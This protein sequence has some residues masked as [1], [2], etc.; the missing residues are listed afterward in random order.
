MKKLALALVCLIIVAF[1]A[2]CTPQGQPS[3]S[4]L[5]EEG[6][7]QNED[8]VNLG[9]EVNFGFTMHSAIETN[10]PLAKL[11]IKVDDNAPDTVVLTG[12]SFTYR[13]TLVYGLEKDEI[14]GS[15]TITATVYDAAGQ[16]ASTSITLNLNQPAQPLVCNRIEWVRRGANVISEEEMANYGLQWT[17]SYNS[18]FA[19]LKP[20]DGATLYV[21]DG[22][23][24]EAINTVTDK[25][26]LFLLLN[27]GSEPVES[28]RNIDTNQSGDYNDMLAVENGDKCFVILIKHAQIETGSFGTQITIS[29][30]AK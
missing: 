18:P 26:S 3:I 19:T 20:V 6:Y 27:E 12:T 1:F 21:C 16:F 7:V 30:E 25:S 10:S 8:V 4:V 2:S 24:F 22:N 9:E 14:I 17:G 11:I 5:N 13:G 28:Y 15:S 23:L 29:G